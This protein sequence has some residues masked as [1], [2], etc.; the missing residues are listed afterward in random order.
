MPTQ[1]NSHP[2]TDFREVLQPS[3][4]QTRIDEQCL[5]QDWMSWNGYKTA[6]VFDTLASEYFAVRSTCSVMDLT[7]MEKYRI[8]G[9]DAQTF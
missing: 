4:F 8:T 1:T 6:R 2:A 9:P 5:V 7:P 3:P